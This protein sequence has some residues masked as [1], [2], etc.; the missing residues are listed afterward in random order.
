MANYMVCFELGDQEPTERERRAVQELVRQANENPSAWLQNN[1]NPPGAKQAGTSES[2]SAYRP[3]TREPDH[4]KIWEK[5]SRS[6]NRLLDYEHITLSQ[7]IAALAVKQLRARKLVRYVVAAE[8]GDESL[9]APAKLSA[10][11]LAVPLGKIQS[12]HPALDGS[13]THCMVVETDDDVHSNGVA[14]LGVAKAAEPTTPVFRFLDLAPELRNRVYEHAFAVEPKLEIEI[15]T[16]R[17]RAPPAAVAITSRQVYK[18]SNTYL[19]EASQRFWSESKFYVVM[20]HR[21]LTGESRDYRAAMEPGRRALKVPHLRQ[22]EFRLQD[23]GSTSSTAR[24]I[25]FEVTATAIPVHEARCWVEGPPARQ[26][27][28]GVLEYLKDLF[29][30]VPSFPDTWPVH[31]PERLNVQNCIKVFTEAAGHSGARPGLLA[32]LEG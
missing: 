32:I 6:E 21:I 7:E 23:V 18:E 24:I 30:Y 31:G 17:S 27:Y 14:H 15:F 2:S 20:S 9:F 12:R 26:Y 4:T 1:G 5:Q 10:A 28:Q 13:G 16:A 11:D 22:L 29:M 25:K 3:P 19:Q 8:N